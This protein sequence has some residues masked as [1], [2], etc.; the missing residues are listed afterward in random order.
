M[1]KPIK[2]MVR[3]AF[4]AVGLDA[5]G[6]GPPKLA[7]LKKE[8]INTVFDIGANIGQFAAEVHSILPEAIIYSFEPL[9]D[10]HGRLISKMKAV[11]GF[12]AFDFALGDQDCETEIYRSEF[13]PSSSLL[14]MAKLHEQLFPHTRGKSLENVKVRRLDDVARDL[15]CP[16]NILVK[17]D[18]QGYEDRVI[19]G[20]R[21]LV[22]RARILFV[23]TSFKTLYVGQPSFGQIYNM[24]RELG[25]SYV[26]S[27]EQVKSPLDGRVL[28][29]DSIFLKRPNES[30]HTK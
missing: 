12:H 15:D 6:V 28:Q 11:S 20:G 4:L 2:K 19:L 3:N 14:P 25:F 26:G 30:G 23:E 17:I 8:N 10:C 13:S 29:S 27:I 22:S 1:L 24:L 18:V 21:E 9:K 7:W 16:E 5:R